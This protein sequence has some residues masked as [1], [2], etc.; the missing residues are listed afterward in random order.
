MYGQLYGETEAATRSFLDHSLNV[1]R[2]N[3]QLSGR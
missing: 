1:T 2:I 3:D